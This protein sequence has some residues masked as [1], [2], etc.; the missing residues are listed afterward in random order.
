[1]LLDVESGRLNHLFGDYTLFLDVFFDF[2]RIV[3][4][5]SSPYLT[6][7]WENITGCNIMAQL[8]GKRIPLQITSKRLTE[9]VV[10]C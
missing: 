4:W 2:L 3:P 8:L 1:M 9:G 10:I 6:T 7:I 5:Y